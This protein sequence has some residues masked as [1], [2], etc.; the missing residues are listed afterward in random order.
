MAIRAPDGANK[1]H[2]DRTKHQIYKDSRHLISGSLCDRQHSL[3][4][5]PIHR[6]HRAFEVLRLISK[7]PKMLTSLLACWELGWWTP[8]TELFEMQIYSG[9]FS[10]NLAIS[11]FDPLSKFTIYQN[12]RA[13]IWWKYLDHNSIL[14]PPFTLIFL[15]H[16]AIKKFRLHCQVAI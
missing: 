2:L 9:S 4:S 16:S 13:S 1:H 14:P 7:T 11:F 6:I 5:V 15:F 10:G 12:G 3:G 8:T